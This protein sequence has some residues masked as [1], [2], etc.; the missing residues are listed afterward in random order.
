MDA[1]LDLARAYAK[2]RNGLEE[3][4]EEI[5][6]LQRKAISSRLRGLRSR[7]AETAA[8]KDALQA[9]I[10]ARPDL[11]VK[12]RTVAVDGVKIGYQKQRGEI[13]IPD[14]DATLKKAQHALPRNAWKKF[15]TISVRFDKAALR[16]LPAGDLAKIGV[17]VDDPFDKVMIK[18]ARGD[19]DKL[20]DA[21]LDDMAEEAK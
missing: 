1:I 8:A 17:T 10:E 9:A 19:L 6:A 15:A 13:V 21:L 4:A 14:E 2:A 16:K 5:R 11:F 7:V 20:V 3:T 12:P 18:A